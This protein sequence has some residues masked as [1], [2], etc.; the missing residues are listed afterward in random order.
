MTEASQPTAKLFMHGRSQAV[1]LPKEFRFAGSEVYVRRQGNDVILSSQPRASIQSL[2][3]ALE[4]F[5]QGHPIVREQP[6]AGVDRAPISPTANV[7]GPRHG[8]RASRAGK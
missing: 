8:R 3:E 5:E 6:A 4:D 7:G 2:I 1:R